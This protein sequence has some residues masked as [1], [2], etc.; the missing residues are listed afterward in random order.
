GRGPGH[1]PQARR[2]S[3]QTPR[4]QQL[5]GGVQVAQKG[6]RSLSAD[7]RSRPVDPVYHQAPRAE[8][9]SA[10]IPGRTGPGETGPGGER[11]EACCCPREG[12]AAVTAPEPIARILITILIRILIMTH[13]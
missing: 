4:P 5:Q 11:S 3:D 13:P 12:I 10:G 6:A 7:G 1:L 9:A 8:S 2:R